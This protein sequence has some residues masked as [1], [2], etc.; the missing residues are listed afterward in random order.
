[1]LALRFEAELDIRMFNCTKRLK[2]R[3]G[4]LI[5]S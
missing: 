4:K 1:M 5:V 3:A 2:S